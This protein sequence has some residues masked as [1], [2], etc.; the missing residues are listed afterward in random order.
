MISPDGYC[1]LWSVDLKQG[2]QLGPP[3]AGASSACHT[4]GPPYVLGGGICCKTEDSCYPHHKALPKR[5]IEPSSARNTDVESAAQSIVDITLHGDPVYYPD[6]NTFNLF[7][8]PDVQIVPLLAFAQPV[9]KICV[10]KGF[11][12]QFFIGEATGPFFYGGTGG[13]QEFDPSIIVTSVICILGAFKEGASIEPISI[14]DTTDVDS[15]AASTA[16]I[17]F[18][19]DPAVYVEDGGV[20]TVL[21]LVAD[22]HVEQLISFG[23]PVV[24]LC[25]DTPTTCQFYIGTAIGPSF[26][27]ATGGCQVFNPSITLTS[28]Q[29]IDAPFK[30]GA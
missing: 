27:G 20:T 29:C 17:T 25:V 5:S 1:G 24:K 19:G 4:M 10:N 7:I 26:Y 22:A 28:V 3:A 23:E 8:N 2:F 15:A 11:S 16:H 9:A 13:C 30:A 6:G 18:Y 12:C 14:R 21:Q